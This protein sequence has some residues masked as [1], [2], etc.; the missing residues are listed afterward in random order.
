MKTLL[1][2]LRLRDRRLLLK[3][4]LEQAIPTTEQD[5]VIVFVTA[6]GWSQGQ[7]IQ[8]SYLRKI[9]GTELYGRHRSAIQI[10]TAAGLCAVLDLLHAGRLPSSGLIRQEDVA[11]GDFLANR[12]GRLYGEAQPAAL[13]L[14]A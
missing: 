6:S 10:A 11:L 8:H 5:V 4:I 12:F 3:E 1:H 9:Y 13:G 14:V 7:L 2:D